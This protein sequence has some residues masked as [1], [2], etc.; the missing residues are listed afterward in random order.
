L[1]TRARRL[2]DPTQLADTLYRNALVLLAREIDGSAFRLVGVGGESLAEARLADPP[3]LFEGTI[4]HAAR[5]ENAMD[6]IRTKM[7]SGAI[8]RGMGSG[9]SDEV[10]DD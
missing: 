3:D 9:W 4:R 2:A 5:I 1:R 7:G 6:E 10:E 8:A